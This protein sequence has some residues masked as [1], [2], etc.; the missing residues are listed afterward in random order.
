MRCIFHK[1]GWRP[2][3]AEGAYIMRRYCEKCGKRL[4]TNIPE[5]LLTFKDNAEDEE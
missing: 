4:N 5:N 3:R 2:E 1:P